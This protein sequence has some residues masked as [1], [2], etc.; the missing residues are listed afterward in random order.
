VFSKNF[1]QAGIEVPPPG[2]GML[3]TYRI[4]SLLS[5]VNKVE[6]TQLSDLVQRGEGTM[7]SFWRATCGGIARYIL[8]TIMSI[9]V[10]ILLEY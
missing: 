1:N 2:V 5:Y 6:V 8:K 10:C 7:E 4:Q 3:T 9:Y